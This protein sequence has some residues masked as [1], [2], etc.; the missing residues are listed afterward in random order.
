MCKPAGEAAL[1]VNLILPK[2]RKSFAYSRKKNSLLEVKTIIVF[3]VVIIVFVSDD[4]AFIPQRA[5][6]A[7]FIILPLFPT[8]VAELIATPAMQEAAT[9]IQQR[10][11]ALA[12]VISVDFFFT[13]LALCNIWNKENGPYTQIM[14]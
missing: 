6:A 2:M 7:C 5:G 9:H 1:I 12:H 10:F 8:R 4:V 14:W 11:L 3:L 13:I